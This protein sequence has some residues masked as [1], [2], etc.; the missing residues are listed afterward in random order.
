M[1]KLVFSFLILFLFSFANA[2]GVG[3]EAPDF[4]LTQLGSNDF[5]LSD[6]RGKVLFIFWFAYD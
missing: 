2:V 3:D 1:N 6:H 5:T 4:T